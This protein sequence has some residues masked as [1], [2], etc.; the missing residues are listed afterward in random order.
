MTLV[1]C[2]FQ[3][4]GLLFYFN[5]YKRVPEQGLAIVLPEL[6]QLIGARVLAAGHLQRHFHHAV[7]DVVEVLHT[8]YQPTNGT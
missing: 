4:K 2:F 5:Q 1:I 3:I 8:S 6:R 7:P